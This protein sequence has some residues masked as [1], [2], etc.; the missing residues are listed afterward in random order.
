[1]NGGFALNGIERDRK[2]FGDE[3]SGIN[4]V[5]MN[6]ADFGRGNNNHIGLGRTQK[7][8]RLLLPFEIDLMAAG[9]DYVAAAGS[10]TPHDRGANHAA[11]TR[12][13]N[14]LTS[15]IEDLG[16]HQ[17]DFAQCHAL[18]RSGYGVPARTGP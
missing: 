5:G 10:E 8:F 18:S 16:E 14:P 3:F 12:N 4:V 15:E 13:V 1:V 9:R 2:V 11:V 17:I 6:A 7:S